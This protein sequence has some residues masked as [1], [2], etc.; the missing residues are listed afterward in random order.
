MGCGCGNRSAGSADAYLGAVQAV[1][2]VPGMADAMTAG[3]TLL[4]LIPLRE[5]SELSVDLI[6]Q[7]GLNVDRKPMRAVWDALEGLLAMCDPRAAGWEGDT[8][9]VT[10][11]AVDVVAA[12]GPALHVASA[13]IA[14]AGF[15]VDLVGEAVTVPLA[16]AI[17]TV[18]AVCQVLHGTGVTD[19]MRAA[20]ADLDKKTSTTT[21]KKPA[22][23]RIPS[24]NVGGRG[25]LQPV[26]RGAPS[27]E[28][29]RKART[30]CL[31]LGYPADNRK[32]K[33]GRNL[34]SCVSAKSKHTL[35]LGS[36][37]VQPAYARYDACELEKPQPE[38]A[39][40]D[41]WIAWLGIF[42]TVGGTALSFLKR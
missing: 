10:A 30:A 29:V 16:A 24:I 32:N 34:S 8:L 22:A 39:T 5:A 7:L 23:P 42:L 26:T 20:A 37:K 36:G 15:L 18:V 41:D 38:A 21:P 4:K 35:T 17:S 13:A 31:A 33:C 25:G 11:G 1:C 28:A 27:Q 6:E 14:G 19:D 9:R 2:G 40:S 3:R 12:A